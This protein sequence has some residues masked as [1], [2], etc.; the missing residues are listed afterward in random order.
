MC[1]YNK[2]KERAPYSFIIITTDIYWTSKC[3]IICFEKLC[4]S[5][6]T[7]G[8]PKVIAIYYAASIP[9]FFY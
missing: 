4:V 7:T 6:K 1:V 8:L 9:N 5:L 3:G 2:T